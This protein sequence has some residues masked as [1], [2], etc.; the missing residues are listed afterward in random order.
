VL[1]GVFLEANEQSKQ[2]A[3]GQSAW[4]PG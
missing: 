3:V 2:L 4:L 1:S